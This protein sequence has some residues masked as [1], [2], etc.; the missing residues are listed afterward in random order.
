LNYNGNLNNI[1]FW[2]NFKEEERTW[3]NRAELIGL[4]EIQWKTPFHNILVKFTNNWKLD[5]EHNKIKVMLG[6]E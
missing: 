5:P 2:I 4:F 3:A 1:L 6:E